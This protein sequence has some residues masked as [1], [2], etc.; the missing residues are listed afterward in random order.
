MKACPTGAL[1]PA[2]TS[3][4]AAR[5]GVALVDPASCLSFQGLRCEVCY[6]ACPESNKA[7]VIDTTPREQSK[8]AMFL[9][10]VKPDHCTGCGMCEQACP[11]DE[12]AIRVQAREAVLGQIGRHYRLGW[13]D[14]EDPR[15][16]GRH[17]GERTPS[18]DADASTRKALQTLKEY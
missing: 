7:L 12:A 11:T 17:L 16:S 2:L 15:N 6:R 3:V 5:M 4:E 13:L 8:H 14:V 1:D 18:T 9:P 10:V